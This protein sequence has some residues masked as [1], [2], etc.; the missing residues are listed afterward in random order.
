[1]TR[2]EGGILANV[3]DVH[4]L[5]VI[6]RDTRQNGVTRQEGGILA[7]VRDVHILQ[8]ISRD[9]QQNGELERKRRMRKT[10]EA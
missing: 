6:S 5:Q 10:R 8:V 3:R 2:Q 7:N 9:T 1:M 4:I